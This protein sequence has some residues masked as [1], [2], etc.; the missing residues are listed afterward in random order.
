M[1]SAV[2][3]EGRLTTPLS[4]DT[5]PRKDKQAGGGALLPPS[6]VKRHLNYSLTASTAAAAY[7]GHVL[8]DVEQFIDWRSYDARQMS[9]TVPDTLSWQT[10]PVELRRQVQAQ[11][12]AEHWQKSCA[13]TSQQRMLTHRILISGMP[14]FLTKYRWAKGK[15]A[16]DEEHPVQSAGEKEYSFLTF[17]KELDAVYESDYPLNCCGCCGEKAAIGCHPCSIM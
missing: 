9:V 11:Y 14:V 6:L 16:S 7:K 4:L 17:G 5:L 13:P 12:D 1:H 3:L 2:Q 8:C 10:M 15:A